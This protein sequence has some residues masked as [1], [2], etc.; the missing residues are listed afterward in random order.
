M[1]RVAITGVSGY[2]GSRLAQALEQDPGI[3]FILGL[4]RAPFSLPEGPAPS[5]SASGGFKSAFGGSGPGPQRAP[6]N[7][8]TPERASTESPSR[9]AQPQENRPLGRFSPDRFQFIQQDVTVPFGHHLLEHWID[10]L[11]HLVPAQGGDNTEGPEVSR[12]TDDDAVGWPGREPLQD[13]L[14]RCGIHRVIL[15]SCL[16]PEGLLPRLDPEF[17]REHPEVE[18]VTACLMP[19]LG[20]ASPSAIARLL[21]SRLLLLPWTLSALRVCHEQD[22]LNALLALVR[23]NACGIVEI[24]PEDSVSLQEA[25]TLLR[26]LTLPVPRRLA[27]WMDLAVPPHTHRDPARETERGPSR[28]PLE[29]RFQWRVLRDGLRALSVDTAHPGVALTQVVDYRYQFSAHET[30]RAFAQAG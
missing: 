8:T 24:G 26:R 29:W 23:S 17:L 13:A 18:V 14:H 12:R 7:V 9:A 4:D 10:T 6:G 5:S 30:L 11:I 2:L 19:V 25:A 21:R 3:S 1:Q 20:Q 28:L 15:V 22:A 16:Q 27:R